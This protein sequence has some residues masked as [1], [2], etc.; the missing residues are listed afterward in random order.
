MHPTADTLLVIIGKGAGRR[1][2]PGDRRLAV[3]LKSQS[4]MSRV[5]TKEKSCV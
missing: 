5:L 2:M 4:F 3:N 1:V